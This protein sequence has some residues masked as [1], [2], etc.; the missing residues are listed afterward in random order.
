MSSLDLA[1]AATI[2]GQPTAQ[3]RKPEKKTGQDLGGMLR[4]V[5]CLVFT[6]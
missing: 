5:S 4:A 1:T 6:V 3:A 2:Y